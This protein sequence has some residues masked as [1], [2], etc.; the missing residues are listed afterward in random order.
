MCKLAWNT[1]EVHCVNTMSWRLTWS[2]QE[3]ETLST[4]LYLNSISIQYSRAYLSFDRNDSSI[5]K[6]ITTHKA[7]FGGLA[8]SGLTKSRRLKSF[9]A[10]VIPFSNIPSPIFHKVLYRTATTLRSVKKFESK[11]DILLIDKFE[12]FST[13]SPVYTGTS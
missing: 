4:G 7:E 9:D 8:L 1:R 2:V 13:K 6:V 5:I 10:G 11:N 12:S 3:W